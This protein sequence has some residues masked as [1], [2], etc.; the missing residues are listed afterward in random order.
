MALSTLS[1][2]R[3]VRC[4]AAW[5]LPATCGRWNILQVPSG[6]ACLAGLVPVF[7]LVSAH[8]NVPPWSLP[9]GL[10]TVDLD[11]V[12]A[13]HVL[14]MVLPEARGRYLLCERGTLMSDIAAMLR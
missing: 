10:T 6:A 2:P 3:W 5:R 1:W 11:D 4:A 7:H 13:A 14:A 8:P 12:A 9:A